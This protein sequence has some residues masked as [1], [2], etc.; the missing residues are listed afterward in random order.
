MNSDLRELVA[1]VV[2]PAEHL[3]DVKADYPAFLKYTQSQLAKKLAD[4]LAQIAEIETIETPDGLAVY[5]RLFVTAKDPSES[6]KCTVL[7]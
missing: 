2:I 7:H 3:K 6:L 1:Y 5:A 4:S